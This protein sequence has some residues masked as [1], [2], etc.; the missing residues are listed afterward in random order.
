MNND[1]KIKYNFRLPTADKGYWHRQLKVFANQFASMQIKSVQYGKQDTRGL[2]AITLFDH[3]G[4]VPCHRHF[5]DSTAL[6]AFVE[7]YN[8]ACEGLETPFDIFA[9]WKKGAK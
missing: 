8:M 2:P 7:G 5:K 4:C 1:I 3:N 6:L 9:I